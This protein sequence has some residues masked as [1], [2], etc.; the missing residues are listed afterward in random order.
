MSMTEGRSS[1]RARATRVPK[2]YGPYA[3]KNEGRSSLRA[4]AAAHIATLLVAAGVLLL[5]AA[6]AMQLYALYAQMHWESEQQAL[7]TQ[8]LSVPTQMVQDAQDVVSPSPAAQP[9]PTAI[10]SPTVDMTVTPAA[11]VT[12][13]DLQPSP[14]PVSTPTRTPTPLP[15]IPSDPG[16]LIVTKLK[17]TARIVT[18]PVVNGQ[19]DLTKLVYEVGL[20][21]GT[22]FPGQPGN[23]ALSGHVSLLRRGDGPFRWLEKLVL[24]DEIIVQ[25]DNTRYIYRVS[26]TRVVLPSDVTVLA[27][28]ET[29]TLTLITCTDWNVLKADY[30]KRLIVTATLVGQRTIVPPRS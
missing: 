17:L 3:T 11:G 28:T 2:H 26:G 25:Q 16:R 6:G 20:L 8:F 10:P 24:D 14:T 29:P 5:A 12:T 23:A 4:R 7:S 18:V 1:L 19:W 30:M 13:S 15:P 27:S 21:A 9:S 22:G